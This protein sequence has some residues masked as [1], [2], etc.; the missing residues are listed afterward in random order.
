M[1][2]LRRWCGCRKCEASRAESRTTLARL[3]AQTATTCSWRAVVSSSPRDAGT[4]RGPRRGATLRILLS[5]ALSSTWGG[6][7][8]D[9]AL[10]VA[11]RSTRFGAC[12]GSLCLLPRPLKRGVGS[13]AAELRNGMSVSSPS[14]PWGWRRGLGRGGSSRGE[15]EVQGLV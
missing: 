9:E 14:P 4:G 15:E 5:P 6:R 3:L 8:G 12:A 7:E 13:T 10:S 11:K 2:N 1:S